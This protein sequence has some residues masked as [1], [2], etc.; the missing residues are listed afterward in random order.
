MLYAPS[1][2]DEIVFSGAV[3]GG[4]GAVED[5]EALASQGGGDCALLGVE[6]AV[7]LAGPAEAP[8]VALLVDLG[9]FGG[10]GRGL[11]RCFHECVHLVPFSVSVGLP[12]H[13]MKPHDVGLR[14][15]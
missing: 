14:I 15:T 9:L 11:R 8:T 6:G 7:V 3:E 12:T 13:A 10:G 5:G 1:H 2:F 4:G